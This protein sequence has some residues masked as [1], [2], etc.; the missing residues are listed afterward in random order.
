MDSSLVDS[1]EG[2]SPGDRASTALVAKTFLRFLLLGFGSLVALYAIQL[3]LYVGAVLVVGSVSP[4]GFLAQILTFLS[5]GLGTLLVATAY[6]NYSGR[7]WSF[8][9]VE[10]PGLRDVAW[11]LGGF[12]ILLLGF[13]AV[14]SAF[15]VLGVSTAE[16]SSTDT[17]ASASPGIIALF[18]V[19]SLLVIG[20][21][22]ELLYRNVIQKS[23]YDVTSK[24]VAVVL[25]GVIFAAVHIPAYSAG[26]AGPGAVASTLVAIFVLSLVLGGVYV[27]TENVLV[28]A[29]I[30]GLY[31]ALSFYS[32]YATGGGASEAMLG[33]F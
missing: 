27:L 3:V 11:T 18:V 24:P 33:L 26:G 9:D 1:P 10:V 22:E 12:V 8:V 25:G 16:H 32:T 19:A 2:P 5:L 14:I 20:P 13:F 31:N 4:T 28:P 7:D 21:G 30:H 6:L 15:D 17:V 29:V 23:M